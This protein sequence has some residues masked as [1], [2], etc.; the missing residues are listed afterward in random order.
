[1][2]DQQWLAEYFEQHRGRL[3]AVAYRMLGSLTEADDAVQEAWPDWPAPTPARVR[4]PGAAAASPAGR[5]SA[6]S[7]GVVAAIMR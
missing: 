1:M 5:S 2:N 3:R 6:R 4:L 7:F